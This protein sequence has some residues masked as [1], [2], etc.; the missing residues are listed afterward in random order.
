M[1][2]IYMIGGC[3]ILVILCVGAVRMSS[4]IDIHYGMA[5][6]PFGLC[7]PVIVLSGPF[8]IVDFVWHKLVT[9]RGKSTPD[10]ER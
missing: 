5:L 2:H 6:I 7:F 4:Q 1:G 3:V 9:K 10:Q 8:I